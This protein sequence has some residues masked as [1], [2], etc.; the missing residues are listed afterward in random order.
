MPI[1]F[2]SFQLTA[3]YLLPIRKFDFKPHDYRDTP[4]PFAFSGYWRANGQIHVFI[5]YEGVSCHIHIGLGIT[6]MVKRACPFNKIQRKC[7]CRATSRGRTRAR[8]RGTEGQ[9]TVTA[10]S[11]GYLGSTRTCISSLVTYRDASHPL[12][13]VWRPQPLISYHLAYSTKWLAI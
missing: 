11:R 12:S 6:M 5:Y 3:A 7:S 2:S 1:T 4:R 9:A 8:E 10:P 13:L